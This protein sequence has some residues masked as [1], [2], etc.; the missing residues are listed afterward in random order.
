[1]GFKGLLK[2]QEAALTGLAQTDS[3][4]L[5]SSCTNFNS[6]RGDAADLLG[7]RSSGKSAARQSRRNDIARFFLCKKE[8]NTGRRATC[9]TH[10]RQARQSVLGPH[11]VCGGGGGDTHTHTHSRA[12]CVLE[13][14]NHTHEYIVFFKKS[15]ARK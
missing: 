7:E 12:V 9:P 15:M 5:R 6:P 2:S 1:M 4:S 3:F 8:C 13:G 11:G 10:A 14:L